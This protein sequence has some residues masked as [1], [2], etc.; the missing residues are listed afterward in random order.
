MSR[1][2][3]LLAAT[4]EA[5]HSPLLRALQAG[6][7]SLLPT[8]R[9]EAWRWTDLRGRLRVL[10]SPS[11]PDAGSPASGAF[12]TLAVTRE[13]LFVNGWRREGDGR[14][15]VVEDEVVRLRFVSTAAGAH[16][17]RLAI[18]IAA[19]ASLTLLESYEGQAQGYVSAVELDLMVGPGALVER[20]VIQDDHASGIS[21]SLAEVRVGEGAR[22]G[23]SVFTSGSRLQR[24]ETHVAHPGRGAE[25]RL[26]AAYV[27]AAETHADLTS[28]VTH[29]GVGGLTAQVA[30]GVVTDR[31]RAVFQ[32]RIVVAR[33]ADGTDARLRHDALSLSDGAEV[34]AKPELEIY[35]DDV[36]CA[37][38]NTIGALD[39][40]TLFYIRSR[41][42]GLAE[43]RTLLM[44]AFLG[45]VVERVAHQAARAVVAA[46]TGQLL[47]ELGR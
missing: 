39:E 21:V 3:V 41:G 20:I 36:Q 14:L 30:K 7:L 13:I 11:A 28:V 44:E 19:G 27:L 34:D 37:H 24:H 29:D 22:F 26:D 42:V 45:A 31:A 4:D 2:A 46:W 16:G 17:A 38:G 23:Q 43:A 6:D 5:A 33:G 10:P 12:A 18:E 25:V 8:R 15:K 9:D 35:A 1:P 47:T 32:G 40:D